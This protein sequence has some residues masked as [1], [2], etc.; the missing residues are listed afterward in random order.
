M[1]ISCY[2]HNVDVCAIMMLDKCC[3]TLGQLLV[4]LL[5]GVLE[6]YTHTPA[7]DKSLFLSGGQLNSVT[8]EKNI[9]T[10]SSL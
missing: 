5:A 10:R 8:S 2:L 1:Q 9:L 7:R 3:S 6:F 4:L